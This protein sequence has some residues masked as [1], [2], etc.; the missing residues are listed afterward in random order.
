[1]LEYLKSKVPNRAIIERIWIVLVL[2]WALVRALLVGT[3]FT[4]YGVNFWLYL[5]IDLASSIPYAIAS[6]RLVFLLIDK[7]SSGAI[8]WGFATIFF[9]YLPDLYIVLVARH[10]PRLTYIGFAVALLLLT[11]LAIIQLRGKAKK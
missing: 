10:V 7:D 3:F 2:V 5:V 4:Q 1:M 11:I 9:F 8:K 6:A